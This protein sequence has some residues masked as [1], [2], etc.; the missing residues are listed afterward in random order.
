[1]HTSTASFDW[2][3]CI[4]TLE[5]S[6]LLKR[7]DIPKGIQSSVPER[8]SDDHLLVRRYNQRS[9]LHCHWTDAAHGTCMV[10]EFEN[11]QPKFILPVIL[12]Y[13]SNRVAF[14]RNL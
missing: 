2:S 11:N 9:L 1:M 6:V 7:R 12:Y 5:F 3:K 4:Q 13:Y 14:E 10:N 8:K